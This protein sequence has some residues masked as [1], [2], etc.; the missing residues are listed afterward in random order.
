MVCLVREREGN[1]GEGVERGDI[2]GGEVEGRY[3]EEIK[4]SRW[5]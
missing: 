4:G 1:G 3:V 2:E 5:I